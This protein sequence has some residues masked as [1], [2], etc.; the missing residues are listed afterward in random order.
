MSEN[1]IQIKN[2]LIVQKKCQLV[3]PIIFCLR[4]SPRTFVGLR[5]TERGVRESAVVCLLLLNLK[6]FN[7]VGL[8]VSL[9]TERADRKPR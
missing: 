5:K 6:K 4:S 2:I 1:A 8:N 7:I 9:S 3:S